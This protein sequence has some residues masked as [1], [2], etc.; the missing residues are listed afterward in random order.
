MAVRSSHNLLAVLLLAVVQAHPLAQPMAC[1][2]PGLI[3]PIPVVALANPPPAA[4]ART[5][6]FLGAAVR[7]HLAKAYRSAHIWK[8]KG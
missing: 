4:R 2:E 5:G 6:A 1:L 3:Q 8:Q 7:D